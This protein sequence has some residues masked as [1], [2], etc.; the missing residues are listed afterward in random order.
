MKIERSVFLVFLLSLTNSSI[1]AQKELGQIVTNVQ[2]KD[3][4]AFVFGDS[5]I[6][7]YEKKVGGK[8]I[9]SYALL[10]S[11]GTDV[12]PLSW[13]V[14]TEHT[15]LTIQASD[16]NLYA[17]FIDE[18]E[19][20]KVL[21]CMVA[22]R[23]DLV[24][25]LIPNGIP[26][27]QTII[28]AY[29]DND[30]H[31]VAFDEEDELLQIMQFHNAR[32]SRILEAALPKSFLKKISSVGIIVD[33]I[34]AQPWQARAALKI[35]IHHND[36][37]SLVKYENESEG[38]RV[39]DIDFSAT[40]AKLHSY[41]VDGKNAVSS[42]LYEGQLYNLTKIGL[43]DKRFIVSISDSLNR[44]LG[45]V[46]ISRTTA[47][48]DSVSYI[49]ATDS[50]RVLDN[51]DVW[52]ALSNMGKPFIAVFPYDSTRVILKL[53]THTRLKSGVSPF[54]GA[55]GVAGLVGGLVAA[56]IMRA[57]DKTVESRDLYFYLIGNANTSFT[58]WNGSGLI[59]H[60]IDRSEIFN[61]KKPVDYSFKGYTETSTSTIGIYQGKKKHDP[62]R[63]VKYEK[64]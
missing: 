58:Y 64:P 5:V 61:P 11:T 50:K 51:R 55:F 8:K 57:L 13:P 27:P 28:G 24:M 43:E 54:V 1:F 6:V 39:L 10:S 35:Y 42:Y 60:T 36:R 41:Q 31:F 25:K 17:Y 9:R 15:I 46:T 23:H 30:L 4:R 7:Q 63:I 45:T 59:G 49:R 52:D 29:T 53:G 19:Q 2:Q 33:K 14:A 16:D 38:T 22:S 26:L 48:N 32:M 37:V 47:Y 44:E 18:S 40:P 34:G 56:G 21:R 12:T 62:L 3:A 20:T